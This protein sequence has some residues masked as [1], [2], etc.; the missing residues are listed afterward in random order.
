[1]GE[2]FTPDGVNL[3][4]N[5]IRPDVEARDLPGTAR[6]EALDRALRVLAS[7]REQG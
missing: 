5:G 6:D 4:G 7:Q 1:V 2:Y 3:A